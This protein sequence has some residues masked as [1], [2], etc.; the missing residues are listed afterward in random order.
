MQADHERE[1]LRRTFDLAADTYD[2]VRPD[3]PDEL[4]DDLIAL[5]GLAPGEHLLE[6]GCA[7]GKA[8]RP[9]ARRGF[10]ITCVELGVELAAA[11]AEN[12]AGFGVEVVQG[13]FETWPPQE[14]ARLVYAATAWHWVDPAVKYQRAW[15]ALASG[16]H[17]AIWGAGHVFPD[18]GDSFFRELQDVYDEIGEGMKPGEGYYRPG[19][20]PDERAEIEASGLFEVIA[21]RHY[22]WEQVYDAREYIELLGTFSGHLAMADW[23]RERLYGEIRRRLALRPGQS[24]RRHWGAALQVARRRDEGRRDEGSRDQGAVASGPAGPG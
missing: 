21:V 19:E 5:T 6:V 16:G 10:R 18:G 13:Q 12:L 2:R 1:R 4:F 17:L 24:V 15:Q 23:K 20:Q 3:Y 8:T 9:L 11:A 14:P 7:T 22:D